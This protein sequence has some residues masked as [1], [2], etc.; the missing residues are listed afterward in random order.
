MTKED[1]QLAEE[2]DADKDETRKLYQLF[3]TSVSRNEDG[4]ASLG[5][6]M[7][8]LLRTSELFVT[9]EQVSDLLGCDSLS[10]ECLAK[11][12]ERY[13]TFSEFVTLYRKNV[14]LGNE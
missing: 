3:T 7:S 2:L 5:E 8:E 12:G 11:A 13:V 10:T 4:K 14:A 6:L 1:E 9:D